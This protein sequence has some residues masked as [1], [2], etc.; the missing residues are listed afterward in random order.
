MGLLYPYI[1][2]MIA[3]HSQSTAGTS[4]GGCWKIT[5][6]VPPKKKQQ[7]IISTESNFGII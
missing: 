1:C 5:I 6:T 4:A 7:E 2:Y 3:A